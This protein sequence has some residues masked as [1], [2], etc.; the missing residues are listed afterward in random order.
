MTAL[1]RLESR[2]PAYARNHAGA[3][4]RF[5]LY[6]AAK[7]HL[8]AGDSARALELGDRLAVLEPSHAGLAELR[9]EARLLEAARLYVGGR[10]PEAEKL[11]AELVG[12]RV[13][14]GDAAAALAASLIERHR[15]QLAISVL[16]DAL[17]RH[18]HAAPLEALMERALDI[19]YP[20]TLP[21]LDGQPE[22]AEPEPP[23]QRGPS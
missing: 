10:V 17:R 12:R 6:Q 22:V 9:A 21:V 18:P 7:Q 8:W 14:G 2:H 16:S 15:A 11:T 23:Q 4:L 3:D 5:A 20:N 1:L 13:V 19:R